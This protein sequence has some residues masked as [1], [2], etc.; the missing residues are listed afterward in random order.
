MTHLTKFRK[1]F[2]LSRVLL[3][4]ERSAKKTLVFSELLGGPKAVLFGYLG[5]L[6][7]PTSP[8]LQADAEL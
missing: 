5:P 2:W 8:S 4:Y 1:G 7:K 6:G 3:H